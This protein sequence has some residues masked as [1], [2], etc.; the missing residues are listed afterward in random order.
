MTTRVTNSSLSDLLIADI[1]SASSSLSVTQQELSSGKAFLRPED[2]PFGT[3]QVMQIDHSKANIAQY[4]DNNNDAQGWL[5]QTDTSLTNIQNL[6][7]RVKELTIEA[8]GTVD[9]TQRSAIADEIDQITEQV[10]TEANASWGGSYIFGGTQT[11]APPYTQGGP[12]NYNGDS[13]TI[14]REIADNTSLDINLTGQQVVGDNTSGL[15]FNLR[16]LST[17]LR[18]NNVNA[19][20][21]TDITNIGNSLDNILSLSAVVGAKENRTEIAASRLSDLSTSLDTSRSQIADADV[22]TLS[23]QFNSRSAALQ[24]A[25]ASAARLIQPTL[26]DYLS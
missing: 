5:Q 24:A 21:S 6:I 16:T 15:L 4:T 2:N 23:I 14:S 18:A 22:S 26:M 13:G 17:D 12:D 10:K 19:L 11:T 25:L 3:V 20:T 1:N 9:A 7:L 8:G